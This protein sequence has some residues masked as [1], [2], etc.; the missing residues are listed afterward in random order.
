[1][2]IEPVARVRALPGYQ[3]GRSVEGAVKLSSNE[4]PHGPLAV[5]LAAASD[6]LASSAGL[7]PDH[8]AYALREA[9]ASHLRVPVASVAVGCG[10]VGLLQQL[11]LAYA[12]PGDE[13][14]YPWPSFIAYPQFA[15]LVGARRVEV[16]LQA[17]A[18][19]VDALLRAV[20]PSTRLVLLA[21]P[22]NPTSTAVGTAD[23]VRLAD[24]LPDGCLL[25]V[26][27]A[28]REY[29]TDPA[30]GDA[31]ELFRGR[32]GVVV[33][34][35]FSKAHA[36]AAL[37]VGYLVGDP[38]VVRAVDAT[39]TPFA[40]NGAGQAAALASLACAGEIAARARVVA[41]MRDGLVDALHAR[42]LHDVPA[43]QGNFVWL[44]SDDAAGLAGALEREGVVT[45]PLGPGVRVTVGTPDDNER[46]L[47]AIDAVLAGVAAP[48]AVAARA[49]AAADG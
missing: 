33:L 34:R 19:D 3:P 1:V 36:L 39:L 26:D 10:S 13:V 32:P 43:S 30:V 18:A 45:R 14:V 4:D 38:S 24:G 37:R 48:T 12:E 6:A 11:L 8:T 25:V 35:T 21:N 46:F 31:V 17:W 42:G 29:V 23:L 28:Y 9:L 5:A 16:P 2:V 20:G 44:P 27:E 22:N 7:Y 41:A 49:A 40:V 47:A 15:E